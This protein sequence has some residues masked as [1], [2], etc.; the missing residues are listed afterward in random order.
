M[1]KPAYLSNDL[2]NDP[3]KSWV[4]ELETDH[5]LKLT[6]LLQLLSLSRGQA[7]E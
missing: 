1:D 5:D 6:I 3:I 7:Q 2:S 4:E